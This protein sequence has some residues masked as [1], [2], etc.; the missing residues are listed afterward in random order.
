MQSRRTFLT[1]SLALGCSAAASPLVTPVTFASAPT[2]NRLVVIVLRGAMDG[3]D[4]VRPVGD[5]NLR[6]Y[7]PTLSTDEALP[8]R[9]IR[10]AAQR[11][12][13]SGSLV[14]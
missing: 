11:I 12:L 8:R 9:L 6:A 5:P 13:D 7:R 10:S 2:D 4:V 14:R 3:L 1:R